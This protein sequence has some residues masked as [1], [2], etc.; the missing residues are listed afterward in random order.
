M[1]KFNKKSKNKTDLA[2]PFLAEIY[3][4]ER[5]RTGILIG[6]LALEG[7]LFLLVYLVYQ[8]E[9]SKLFSTSLAIHAVLIF[10]VIIVVYELILYYFR[11]HRRSLLHHSSVVLGYVN[12]FFEVTLL[13]LLLAFIVKDSGQ[14]TILHSPAALTYFIFI[15]LSTLRLN[16]KLSLFTGALAAAEY[17]L[18]SFAM[19]NYFDQTSVSEEFQT[20]VQVFGMG[21]MLI[22]TAASSGFVASLIRKKIIISFNSLR[23]KNE[24]IDLFG[25]QISPQI[26]RE[27]LSDRS[28]LSGRRKNVTVMFLDIRNFTSFAEHRS[29]EEVVAYLNKL[30]SFMIEIVQENHGII[31]QFLGDGFMATFGAP[32]T[33]PDNRSNAVKA[34]LDILKRKNLEISKGNIPATRIGIGLHS[35]EAVTGNIGS[36]M[37]KQYSIT[38]SVV[39]IASR[40]EG[41]TKQF[42]TELLVSEEVIS[43]LP[44][45]MRSVFNSLG[46]VSVKGSETMISIYNYVSN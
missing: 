41:L 42:E 33:D 31:N 25:Q 22:I 34:S 15:I 44:E 10:L 26:A 12:A 38:G 29:P 8:H 21:I 24:V 20:K 13:S 16:F 6:L 17:V 32:V 7:F 11:Q 2:D 36:E 30:F 4:G 35:G 18:I 5:L 46:E 40:I 45:N 1:K 28:G 3:S 27:I 37:R 43:K 14:V 23:E 39:I 19:N 9:Y